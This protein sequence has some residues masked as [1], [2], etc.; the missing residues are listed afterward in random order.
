MQRQVVDKGLRAQLRTGSFVSGQ[1]FVAMDYFPD[2]PKA[3][4]DYSRK[5]PRFPTVPGET[6]ELRAQAKRLLAK[7]ERIPAEEIG[8]EARA[9]IAS[10]DRT[11]RRLEERTLPGAEKSF[12]S[13]DRTSAAST[14]RSSR[15]RGSCWRSCGRPPASAERAAANAD[16]QMLAPDAPGQRELQDAMREIARAARSVRLLAD[17]LER[18]PSALIRGKNEEKP[19]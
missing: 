11:L 8:N 5:P 16:R 12:A 13:V 14:P 10:L 2:A 7:L 4:I 3:R 18:D 6:T 19:R 1:L 15:R 9:A 17:Y